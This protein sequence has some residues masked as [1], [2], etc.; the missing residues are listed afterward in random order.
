VSSASPLP[1]CARSDHRRCGAM[2]TAFHAAREPATHRSR[3]TGSVLPG[4]RSIS[5]CAF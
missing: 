4:A 3:C 5:E 1:Q 2:A